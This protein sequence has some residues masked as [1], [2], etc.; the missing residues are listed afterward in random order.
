MSQTPKRIRAKIQ[1]AKEKQFKELDLSWKWGR[2]EN[3]RLTQIPVEVFELTQLEV[4]NLS[5]NRLTT[6]PD[7]ITHLQNLASLDLR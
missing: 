7:A 1:E 2:P 5:F 6:I 4:L 3:E